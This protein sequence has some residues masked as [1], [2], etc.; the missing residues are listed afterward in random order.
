MYALGVLSLCQAPLFHEAD[1]IIPILEMG[2]VSLQME[3]PL[4]EVRPQLEP[5][6][7]RHGIITT[8]TMTRT[9]DDVIL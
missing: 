1:T 9:T 5:S 7:G 6:S 3:W 4:S 2:A 8:V